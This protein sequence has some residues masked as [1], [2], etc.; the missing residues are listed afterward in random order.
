MTLLADVVAA[1]GEV[2]GTSARSRKIGVL[3]ELLRRLDPDEVPVAVGFLS[4]TPRQGRVG[5]GYRSA[6]STVHLSERELA[7]HGALFGGPGLGKTTFLQLLVH[8][9][10]VL[11]LLWALAYTL[12]YHPPVLP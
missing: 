7:H 3:A 9:P 6:T 11:F 2:A 5:V 10:L 12:Q 4:G 1:S 8:L